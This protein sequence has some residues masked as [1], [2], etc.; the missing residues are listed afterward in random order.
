MRFLVVFPT[1][2]VPLMSLA[3]AQRLLRRA[4]RCN[5]FGHLWPV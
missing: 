4:K 1:R 3:A 2:T 5:I